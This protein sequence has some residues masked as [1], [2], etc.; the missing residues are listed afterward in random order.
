MSDI[1]IKEQAVIFAR[2]QKKFIAK[3]YLQ[4]IIETEY[5]LSVFM[6]GAPGAGKTEFA[7]RMVKM[8]PQK[9]IIHIDGDVLREKFPGYSGNNS[10]LFQGAMSILVDCMHDGALKR[11]LS[12]VMDSTLAE[13]KIAHKNIERSLKH[14]R[15]VFIFFLDQDPM[16]SWDFTQKRE[17]IEGRRIMKSV[18]IKKYFGSIKSVEKILDRFDDKITVVYIKK[19]YQK[20]QIEDIVICNTKEDLVDKFNQQKY[21]KDDLEQIL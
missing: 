20:G 9:T 2:K 17:L 7:R 4:D 5:P 3:E 13:Y 11:K 15:K 12:F 16:V 21:T 14:K 19:S 6:A 1:E 8:F 18:F 10:F